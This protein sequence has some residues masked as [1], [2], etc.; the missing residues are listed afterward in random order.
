MYATKKICHMQ[1]SLS[2][3]GEGMQEW[4]AWSGDKRESGRQADRQREQARRETRDKKWQTLLRGEPGNRDDVTT[5]AAEA[6]CRR[7]GS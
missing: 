7:G 5:S 1:Q 2:G 6:G 3:K 4:K